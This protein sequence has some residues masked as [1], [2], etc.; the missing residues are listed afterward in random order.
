VGSF[1]IMDLPNYNAVEDED[2]GRRVFSIRSRFRREGDEHLMLESPK[3]AGIVRSLGRYRD[4]VATG[5]QQA[6]LDV[7][8]TAMA[9]GEQWITGRVIAQELGCSTR[10][11]RLALSNFM[12]GGGRFQGV[13]L[14]SGKLGYRLGRP[15]AAQPAKPRRGKQ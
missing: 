6:A 11:V 8:A 14:S 10:N 5:T 2:T 7:I 12:R 3:E 9:E 13:V 1:V 4:V 15:D